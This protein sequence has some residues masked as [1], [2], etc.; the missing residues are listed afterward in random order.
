MA[1]ELIVGLRDGEPQ[2]DEI[3][4]WAEWDNMKDNLATRHQCPCCGG[5]HTRWVR[6]EWNI[7]YDCEIA[8]TME[9]IE[10]IYDVNQPPSIQ[11]LERESTRWEQITYD[12]EHL[13]REV[14]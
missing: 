10:P 11:Q 9:D 14:K 5:G 7:C 3:Q 8:F 13:L 12:I 4:Y 6:Q 1:T 2:P